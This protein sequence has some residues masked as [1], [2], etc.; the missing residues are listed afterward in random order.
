MRAASIADSQL[1]KVFGLPPELGFG[2]HDHLP[3]AP[4]QVEVVDVQRPFIDP[5]RVG[6]ILQAHS[7]HHARRRIGVDVQLRDVGPKDRK[8]SYISPGVWLPCRTRLSVCF[9]IA[10]D[11]SRRGLR[12]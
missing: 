1:G 8:Q 6:E 10:R 11:R 2:L 12:S 3:G 5:Q 4:E 9:C 7:P